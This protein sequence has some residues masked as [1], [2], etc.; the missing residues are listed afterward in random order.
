MI[1]LDLSDQIATLRKTFDDIKAVIGVD[2]L[3]AEIARL[4]TL[5]EAQ[6][7]WDDPDNAQKVTSA[8]SHR[9]AELTRITS[10]ERRLDDL[11]VL[12]GQ[13]GVTLSGHARSALARHLVEEEAA[14]LTGLPVV[15]CHIK[16]S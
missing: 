12:V 8:L 6:D 2:R 3:E 7:L 14:R 5:S 13:S 15:E 9:Q 4:T 1:E 10:I 16:I 11:E